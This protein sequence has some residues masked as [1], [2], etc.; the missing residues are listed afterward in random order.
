MTKKKHMSV[1][2]LANLPQYQGLSKEELEDVRFNIIYGDI[3]ARIEET[4]ASF[5]EDYDLSNMTAN[6]RLA[7]IELARIFV[8][9]DQVQRRLNKL[10]DLELEEFEK[11]NKIISVMRSD[12][13]KLQKDL[14]I[15]RQARQDSGSQSVVDFIEDLKKRA[16]V[17]IQDRLAS[18]Y[19]PECGMLIAKAW[20]LYPEA[21]NRIHLECRR[22]GCKHTFGVTSSELTSGKNTELGPPA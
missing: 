19:C 18:I 9:L 21:D 5:E 22:E 17:F 8:M 3:D 15:T 1:R 12:A 2:Q 7:L 10:E 11:L 20:F 6:D 16:K 4:I 13:S 14:N